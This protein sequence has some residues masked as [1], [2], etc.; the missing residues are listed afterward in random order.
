MGFQV[1]FVQE[2]LG[3]V[4]HGL[5]ILVAEEAWYTEIAITVELEV[6]IHVIN[7]LHFIHSDTLTL[8]TC[9]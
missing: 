6:K 9:S 4:E 5:D 1:E 3:P 8:S 2:L 7:V